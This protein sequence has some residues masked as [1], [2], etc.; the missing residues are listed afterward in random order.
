[1]LVSRTAEY[2][3]TVYAYL[4]AI[5]PYL[6][7]YFLDSCVTC[8]DCQPR[9]LPAFPA[10]FCHMPPTHTFEQH[11]TTPF[12]ALRFAPATLVL[13]V[14]V[15]LY[16]HLCLTLPYIPHSV[17][18]LPR[19]FGRLTL[20]TLRVPRALRVLPYPDMRTAFEP[21]VHLYYCH[22][23]L[24]FVHPLFSLCK[25][26]LQCRFRITRCNSRHAARCRIPRRFVLTCPS[27]K[28]EERRKKKTCRTH[29]LPDACIPVPNRSRCRLRTI[30]PLIIPCSVVTVLSVTGIPACT[31]APVPHI[32]VSRHLATCQCPAPPPYLFP[33]GRLI[34]VRRLPYHAPLRAFWL[35]HND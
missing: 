3:V 5:T 1:M 13:L 33:G 11:T 28:E 16:H 25:H 21:F 17:P 6:V 31:H 14:L 27:Q 32:T 15:L 19:T 9:T 18:T 22:L 8:L 4:M 2:R 29:T 30:P 20:P 7:P 35:L 34:T 23:Y 10:G 24:R 26:L 12:G